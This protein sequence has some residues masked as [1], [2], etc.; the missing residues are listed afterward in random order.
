M[1]RGAFFLLSL[2][3][4]S[5]Q[6]RQWKTDIDFTQS[7]CSGVTSSQTHQ[8][9]QKK[10]RVRG[11][12][13]EISQNFWELR[14]AR[15]LVSGK[16]MKIGGSVRLFEKPNFY[17]ARYKLVDIDGELHC[18]S[19]YQNFS[20]KQDFIFQRQERNL[21][22][23]KVVFLKE[24]ETTFFSVVMGLGAHFRFFIDRFLEA[25]PHLKGIVWAVWTGETSKLDPR[26]TEF[27]T[28]GGLLPLIALS[29]QHVGVLVLV[30]RFL[31][32]YLP[33]RV[34]ESFRFRKHYRK[35]ILFLPVVV[36]LTLT[37]TSFGTPSV[38]RTLAMAVSVLVLRWRCKI[39]STEQLL[40][41]SSAI[42]ISIN[43]SLFEK[44]SFI[45]SFNGAY[46][47]N[48]LSGVKGTQGLLRGYLLDSLIMAVTVVPVVLFFF[49]QWSYLAPVCAVL[50]S[51]LWALV[52]IPAGFLI[53]I[54]SWIPDLLSSPILH[55]LE[56][57]WQYL[58]AFHLYFEKIVSNSSGLFIRFSA[59]EAFLL[60]MALL[61]FVK[62]I[63]EY[64]GVINAR[65]GR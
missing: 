48:E 52:V 20:S 46:L 53:P 7:F 37:V 64:L 26:L 43:P 59:A 28:R 65:R 32:F 60:Q 14:G 21:Y 40:F 11:Y 15:V 33:R 31:L 3:L 9:S 62:S 54:L 17:Q 45:L 29:G 34:V 23:K 63:L 36:C 35:I 19:S 30:C 22:F 58:V 42:L 57:A 47:L 24:S 25:T 16:W 39:C 18:S 55:K 44:G 27:Y 49:G 8:T 50:L 56:A 5:V 13:R 10:K 41:S 2:L 12:L 51:W 61:S 1:F 6:V 38:L 4:V